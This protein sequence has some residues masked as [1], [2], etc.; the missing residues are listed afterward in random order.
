VYVRSKRSC[1][2]R[3]TSCSGNRGGCFLETP[4]RTVPTSS[5]QSEKRSM[6]ETYPR[7]AVAKFA[8]SLSI[9][10]NRLP[11]SSSSARSSTLSRES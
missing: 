8:A 7:T 6:P 5:D 4:N 11:N 1:S 9:M 2:K 3:A 10:A